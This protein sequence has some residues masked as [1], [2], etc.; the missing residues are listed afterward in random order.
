MRVE[1]PESPEIEAAALA[2]GAGVKKLSLNKAATGMGHPM[3]LLTTIQQALRRLPVL[4]AD[5][6]VDTESPF[7]S[8]PGR[9][10]NRQKSVWRTRTLALSRGRKLPRTP[11]QVKRAMMLLMCPRGFCIIHLHC[12]HLHA[13]LVVVQRLLHDGLPC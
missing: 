2:V 4:V 5:E 1:L 11:I 8:R 12:T 10:S 3:V 9:E 6:F 7:A 13:L